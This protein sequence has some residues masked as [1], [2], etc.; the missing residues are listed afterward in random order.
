MFRLCFFFFFFS[1]GL[2]WIGSGRF[3]VILLSFGFV[4]LTIDDR[5]ILRLAD[6]AVEPW[7][8]ATKWRLGAG[9]A[10]TL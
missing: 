1:V 2:G 5:W 6:V 4:S 8:F 10:I 3:L 7:Q 9:I